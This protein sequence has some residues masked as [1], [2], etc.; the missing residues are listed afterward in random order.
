MD[1]N[2]KLTDKTIINE[3]GI[4]LYQI[5]CIKDFIHAKSGEL[6][7]YIQSCDN[8]SGD[9]WVKDNA[10]VW[11]NANISDNAL[12]SDNARI[13]G[14]ATIYDNAMIG[15]KSII[16]GDVFIY[17]EA[18]VSGISIINGDIRIR[19][20]AVIKNSNIYGNATIDYNALIEKTSDYMVIVNIGSR[21]DTT[22][23]Y[24]AIDGIRIRCGCFNGTLD[25]FNKKVIKTHGDN[26]Y[27]KQYLAM[28][29]MIKKIYQ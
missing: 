2:Y 6:G 21:N 27:A 7:G 3:Y 26:K 14:D 18:K 23:V 13:L 8:L 24:K 25:E 15:G 4:K 11:G 19:N 28:I 22:T 17:G 5:E 20:N 29:E 16:Y 9:A 1:R 10:Q 12:I